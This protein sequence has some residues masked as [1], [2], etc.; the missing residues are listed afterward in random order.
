MA[1]ARTT[2]TDR[3]T[4]LPTTPRSR[5]TMMATA[6]YDT[7]YRFGRD[8]LRSADI[9]GVYRYTLERAWATARG[10][11]A[12]VMFNPSTADAFNDD[13]T[14]RRCMRFTCAWGFGAMEVV[15]LY[16]LRS[17]NPIDVY[18]HEAP[19][20]PRNDAAIHAAMTRAHKV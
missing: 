7:T 1:R 6:N 20:G 19:I 3:R 11:V 10:T 16:A 4:H 18:N 14:I 15:N 13:P 9:D 12:W 8:L 17:P 2:T 5:G